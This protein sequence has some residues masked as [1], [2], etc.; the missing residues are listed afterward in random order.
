[1]INVESE[2]FNII[3]KAVR[4]AYPQ[5]YVVGEYVKSPPKFP[6]ISIVEMDN[7]AYER[8][9]TSGSL[10]NHADLMYEVNVYSNKTSGKKSECKAIASLID[11]EFA[12]LGFSRTM[13]QPIPNVDDATIYR[14]LGRYRGVVSKDK[15]IFRR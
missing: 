15:V 9:Q 13:L 4:N 10:E 6:C 1:M 14:M 7:T 8:T 11:N 3:A 12:T 2:I 5:A